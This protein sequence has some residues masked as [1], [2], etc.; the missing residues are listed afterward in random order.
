MAGGC[1]IM[2]VVVI[3]TMVVIVIVAMIVLAMQ[4]QGAV[5]THER[6]AHGQEQCDCE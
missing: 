3:V 6:Q 1:V 5:T 4:G 2:I